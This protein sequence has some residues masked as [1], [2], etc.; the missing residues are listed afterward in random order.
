MVPTL[1]PPRVVLGSPR[2]TGVGG[3]MGAAFRQDPERGP[4]A[5]FLQKT[6]TSVAASVWGLS[7]PPPTW[8]RIHE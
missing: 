7:L 4:E 5:C 2:G 8:G 3:N 6:V 1:P